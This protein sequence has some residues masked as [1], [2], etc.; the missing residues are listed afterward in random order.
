MV[1]HCE[2]CIKLEARIKELEETFEARCASLELQVKELLAALAS[3]SRNSHKPP[4]SDFPSKVGK[5]SKSKSKPNTK[6]NHRPG[7]SRKAFSVDDIGEF[8]SLHPSSC[9][10]C[11]YN[12]DHI[13]ATS[14][15]VSQQIDLPKELELDI[16]EYH[17]SVVC[18]PHCRKLSCGSFPKGSSSKL[19]GPRLSAFISVLRPRFHLSVRHIQDFLQML[20]GE[21]GK[22]SLG[23]ISN[24]E[25]ATSYA[26]KEVYQSAR[27]Y[28][29]NHESIWVDETGWFNP[30]MR[31][32]LWVAS[33]PELSYFQI[34]Q[35][36]SQIALKKLIGDYNGF[37]TSDRWSSYSMHPLEKRQLC[38]S[39]LLRD[40]QKVEDQNLGSENLGK[41]GVSEL[42]N[43]II[44]WNNYRARQI[45]KKQLNIL[46]RPI[47]SR[48]KIILN[49][50]LTSDNRFMKTLSKSLLKKWE[51]IWN[52]CK[53]P[54]KVE[55]TNNRAE[56]A[57]RQQVIWRKISQGTKSINGIS[58]AQRLMTISATL[59]QQKRNLLEFVETMLINFQAGLP[60]PQLTPQNAI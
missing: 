49:K 3:T 15:R 1:I 32:W 27:S 6:G 16:V 39:H 52:F 45:S 10:H 19:V 50:G 17:R 47:R 7:I 12:L 23:T 33:V 5:R 53:H 11:G 56:R 4:S 51:A 42:N 31:P 59:K 30:K 14:V 22:I 34:S 38:L 41:Q 54:D 36:R 18:C 26:S 35:S 2:N 24:I 29:E 21:K 60:P 58:F 25:S 13:S 44:V 28:I 55:P 48:F 40:F 57:L 43:A 37:L 9:L 20:F 8:V 46:I